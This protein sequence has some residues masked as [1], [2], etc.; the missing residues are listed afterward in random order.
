MTISEGTS[1]EIPTSELIDSY[2]EW[3]YKVDIFR[4]AIEL[5]LWEKVASGQD[6]T[7]KLVVSQG[8]DPLGTRMLLDGI[9]SLNLLTRQADRFLLTPEA[10]TYLLPASPTYKGNLTL[11][12]TGWEGNGK[13]AESIR[14]GKR[15]I[16]YCATT[17]AVLDLWV[18]EYSRGWTHP[19][20][21]LEDADRLWQSL[22][23]RARAGLRLLDVACGPAPKSLALARQ[24]PGVSLTFL[25]WQDILQKTCQAASS[26]GIEK[27]VKIL[28]GDLWKVDFGI[29][30]FDVLWLGNI[31]H[32]FSPDENVHLFRKANRA[33]AHGGLI[34]VNSVAR[35]DGGFPAWLELW[36]YAV[37]SGGA[38]Y[39][40][41][42]YKGMLEK[43]GFGE[44]TDF[45][46]G[47]IRAVKP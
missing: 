6:T 42:E 44:V 21:Y 10:E 19:Q 3:I 27:Q 41:A 4:C 5:R 46:K 38:G 40:F 2:N 7:E 8:W 9:C 20:A 28:P 15:P 11:F 25:D 24:H 29:E 14:S 22:E 30:L 26:L 32:F 1:S 17:E 33:L 16:H 47:P 13:L 12:E 37:S 36:L 34:V 39:D 18:E 31:T 43:A 35:R 23:I 45:D